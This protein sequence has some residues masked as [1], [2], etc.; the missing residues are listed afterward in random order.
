LLF[1][2]GFGGSGIAAPAKENTDMPNS[3][4]TTN[5]LELIT[6]PLVGYGSF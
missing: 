6:P 2:N 4:P 5:F 3:S 1:A